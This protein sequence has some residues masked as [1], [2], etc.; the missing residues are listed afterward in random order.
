M[1]TGDTEGPDRLPEYPGDK[2]TGGEPKGNLLVG[3]NGR[4]WA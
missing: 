4:A 3:G 2:L 1:L